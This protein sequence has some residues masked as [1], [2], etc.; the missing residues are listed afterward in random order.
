[1]K[2]NEKNH[3]HSP[4]LSPD[5]LI[6]KFEKDYEDIAKFSLDEINREL[7]ENST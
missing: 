5:R 4:S 3:K 7:D 6:K 2:L 1:M